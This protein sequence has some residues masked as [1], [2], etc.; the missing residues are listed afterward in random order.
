[1]EHPHKALIDRELLKT[2]FYLEYPTST[3]NAA[4]K[5]RASLM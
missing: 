4:R 1:L 2:G 5:L 3:I